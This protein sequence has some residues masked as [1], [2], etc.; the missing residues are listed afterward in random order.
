M[1]VDNIKPEKIVS[2]SPLVTVQ[3]KMSKELDEK[4]AKMHSLTLFSRRAGRS[5]G[6]SDLM[7]A[8]LGFY[9]QGHPGTPEVAALAVTSGTSRIRA[10][11][12]GDF[13]T[14][15]KCG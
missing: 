2:S 14:N 12:P 11:P 15:P 4:V 1:K 10:R 6:M 8:Q 9:G 13:R 7:R 3:K 5:P